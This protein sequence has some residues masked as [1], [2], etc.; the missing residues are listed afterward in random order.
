MHMRVLLD[1]KN[2]KITNV[3]LHAFSRWTKLANIEVFNVGTTHKKYPTQ[4]KRR[5]KT[6]W[7]KLKWRKA[8]PA[9]NFP[10]LD[11][12]FLYYRTLLHTNYNHTVVEFYMEEE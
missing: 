3:Q 1:S 7:R 12:E 4:L 5:N 8:F 10:P 2:D 6:N 9:V 11:E